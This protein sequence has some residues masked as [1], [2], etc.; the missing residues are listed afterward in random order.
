VLGFFS[1]L[2]LVMLP[3]FV[4]LAQALTNLSR[5]VRR[6]KE[7]LQWIGVVA[8]VAWLGPSENL[9]V[10]RYA[11]WDAATSF[12]PEARKPQSVLR[13]QRR[14]SRHDELMAVA[15][16]MRDH[17]DTEAVVLTN[18]IIFRMAGRRSIVASH[19][20]FPYFYRLAPSQLP[21]WMAN[22]GGQAAVLYPPAKRSDP[23]A[24]ADAADS[25]AAQDAY[26]GVSEWYI[27]LDEEATLESPAPL[28]EVPGEGWG[29][30]YRLYRV[31]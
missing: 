4:L 14:A 12:L 6:H 21:A 26:Q 30:F 10:A 13:H 31:R 7:V 1:G 11:A 23:V 15:Q 16:W 8:M 17:S 2:K 29:S 24:I 27:L 18:N 28:K 19:H 5:L 9:R 3:L 25:L 20:D 22:V